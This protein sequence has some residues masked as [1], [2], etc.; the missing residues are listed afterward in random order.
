MPIQ[1]PIAASTERQGFAH[2]T[3]ALRHRNYRLFIAGQSFSL[4]GTWMQSIALSWLIY[5][6]TGSAFLLGVIGST[7]QIP[8]TLFAPLAGVFADR[9]NLHRTIII[10]Q[11][12]ALIQ[13]FLLA[14]LV[15]TQTVQ[16]WQI[17]TLSLMLGFINAFDTPSRQSFIVQMVDDKRDLSNAIAVNSSMV[18]AAR[19]I[20]PSIAGVLIA[21]IGEGACF[22]VNG[23][24]YLAV[25]IALLAM[26]IVPKPHSGNGGKVLGNLKEGFR[27][28]FATPP[29][30]S[31]LL[32]MAAISIIGLPYQSLLPIFAKDILHGGPKM[33]GFLMGATGVGALSGA[34]Y[35]AS[36]R[37]VIGLDRVLSLAAGLLGVGLVFFSLSRIFWLSLGMMFFIGLGMMTQVASTNTLVQT[38]VDDDKR[39]RV[40]SLF[41]LS[42]MGMVPLGTLIAGSVASAIGAP[43][44]LAINGS[45]CIVACLIFIIQLPKWRKQV[46]PIYVA[47][48]ILPPFGTTE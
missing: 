30:R 2:L 27:Y 39:G 22:L 9:W 13:A 24:S 41:I 44:T 45:V 15:F 10:T 26:R 23:F 17:I 38:I 35:L 6:L 18:N 31:L 5:R 48:G 12:L 3:R 8:V 47:K 1:T 7:N 43:L 20:G 42:F 37:N 34:V 25:I 46:R 11:S 16:V 40:V 19:L 4:I 33:L 14:A 28:A 36:R 32:L 21:W 29:I